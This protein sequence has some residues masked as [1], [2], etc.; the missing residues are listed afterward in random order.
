[1]YLNTKMSNN[2]EN[3]DFTNIV[4]EP[5]FS[6]HGKKQELLKMKS[7]TT[8]INKI[9]SPLGLLGE[10]IEAHEAKYATQEETEKPPEIAGALVLRV[11]SS[12]FKGLNLAKITVM[13]KD[14]VL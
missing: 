1:M 8:K 10:R 12:G 4:S 3:E 7:N 6:K 5:L 2:I 11:S 9:P 14:V 13:D